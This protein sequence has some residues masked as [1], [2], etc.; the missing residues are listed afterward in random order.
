[1]KFRAKPAQY[2]CFSWDCDKEPHQ[3]MPD[4]LI[5]PLV[6]AETYTSAQQ[7]LSAPRVTRHHEELTDLHGFD[8]VHLHFYQAVNVGFQ[9]LLQQVVFLILDNDQIGLQLHGGAIFWPVRTSSF[10]ST[11]SRNSKL[12]SLLLSRDRIKSKKG[13]RPAFSAGELGWTYS[14]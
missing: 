7:A 5:C 6:A 10:L 4:I 14:K 12:T 8:A 3:N 11:N 9:D 1:M 13:S 2:H